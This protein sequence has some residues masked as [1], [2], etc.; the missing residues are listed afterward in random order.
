MRPTSQ[1]LSSSQSPWHNF[2]GL[3]ESLGGFSGKTYKLGCF[4]VGRVVVGGFVEGRGVG[5][6]VGGLDGIRV[7][8]GVGFQTQKSVFEASVPTQPGTSTISPRAFGKQYRPVIQSLSLS[9][10]PS[11]GP[12][13]LPGGF[14]FQMNKFFPSGK[15]VG[16]IPK[17]K[18]LKVQKSVPEESTP[19]QPGTSIA[20]PSGF[21]K[22]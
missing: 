20:T 6:A 4:I 16:F 11:H 8:F 17:F 15:F 18:F 19:I 21:E 1:S 7:G 3:S 13:F 14:S 5:N 12:S 10:S 9:Q 22:Q 2:N